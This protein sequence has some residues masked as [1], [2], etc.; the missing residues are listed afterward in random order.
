MHRL[1]SPPPYL[2]SFPLCTRLTSVIEGVVRICFCLCCFCFV[3]RVFS[4][5]CFNVCFVL[6]LCFFVIVFI[7]FVSV[8]PFFL[9]FHSFN[10]Y[11]PFS[12]FFF[13]CFAC[14]TCKCVLVFGLVR[15]VLRGSR[16]VAVWELSQQEGVKG[17]P[18]HRTIPGLLF[19]SSTRVLWDTLFSNRLNVLLLLI[20]ANRILAPP[21][22]KL[23][24]CPRALTPNFRMEIPC[25][26]L[27]SVFF[28]Q[29]TDV[30]IVLNTVG[31]VEAFTGTGQV[32]SRP[33]IGIWSG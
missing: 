7:C 33:D 5:L 26:F 14:I 19:W 2:L 25:V 30:V 22:S 1:S 28:V 10:V 8:A 24:M 29:L 9:F 18:P 21:A 13:V 31:A 12:F 11:P 17:V 15:C 16:R 6:F 3:L 32:S 27:F 4:F 23:E 20:P